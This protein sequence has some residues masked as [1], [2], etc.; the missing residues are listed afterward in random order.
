[1]DDSGHQ[2]IPCHLV[3]LDGS[4]LEKE[5]SGIPLLPNVT[6]F[7]VASLNM[8]LVW[9]EEDI[10]T[11]QGHTM[12]SKRQ[13]HSFNLGLSRSLSN[14]IDTKEYLD[15]YKDKENSHHY[16]LIKETS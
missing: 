8:P 16:N 5:C 2:D 6:I 4:S 9:S 10:Y 13:G 1:M 11:N 12:P 14:H 15:P 7:L 3:A